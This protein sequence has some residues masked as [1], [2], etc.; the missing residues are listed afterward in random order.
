MI[1]MTHAFVFLT[2]L[3][4]W[5]TVAVAGKADVIKVKVFKDSTGTFSFDVTVAS[6]DTGWEKYADR[7]EIV[8]PN[9]QIIATRILAHPHEDEQPF[10]RSLNGVTIAKN[11]TTITVRAHDKREG[12]GGKEITLQVPKS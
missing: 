10:T 5:T 7:W 11:V 3:I 9:G 2:T 6:D 4:L 8:A 12:F 1:V